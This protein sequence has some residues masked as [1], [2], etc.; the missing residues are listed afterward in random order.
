M[1]DPLHIFCGSDV[2]RK[3]SSRM[4]IP[5]GACRG[6]VLRVAP[7]RRWRGW[8]LRIGRCSLKDGSGALALGDDTDSQGLALG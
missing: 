6:L 4:D 8:T 7:G 1:P 2:V 3:R 5:D